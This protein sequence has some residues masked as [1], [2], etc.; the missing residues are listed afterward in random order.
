M[1]VHEGSELDLLVFWGTKRLGFEF[2][3]SDAPGRTRSMLVAKEALKLDELTVVYPG[4]VAYELG[5]GIVVKPLQELVKYAR[6]A[7]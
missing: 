1:R 5:E 3:Y 2:K 7:A 6:R 4:P